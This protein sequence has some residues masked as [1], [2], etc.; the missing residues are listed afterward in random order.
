[1]AAST[2][3]PPKPRSPLTQA[4]LTPPALNR[5]PS[6][7]AH[8]STT[9][10]NDATTVLTR[11]RPKLDSRSSSSSPPKTGSVVSSSPSPSPSP[12][13]SGSPSRAE[14]RVSWEDC[15]GKDRE[16]YVSFPDFDRVVAEVGGKCWG[17]GR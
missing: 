13:P 7:H 3:T 12:S 11:L 1:M 6:H 16:G 17:P 9:A 5:Q 2:P 15:M 8:T 14:G 10:D 4:T